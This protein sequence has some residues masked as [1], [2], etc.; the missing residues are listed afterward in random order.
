MSLLSL[1]GWSVLLLAVAYVAASYGPELPE[2]CSPQVSQ[3]YDERFKESRRAVAG[4]SPQY[5]G[6]F[7]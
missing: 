2:N 3:R 1:L 4:S 5:G 6:T 7:H